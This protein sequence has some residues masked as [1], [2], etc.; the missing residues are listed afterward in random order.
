MDTPNNPCSPAFINKPGIKPGSSLS[1]L[2]ITGKTSVSKNCEHI[3]FTI[4]CSS[5]NSSGIK[6]EFASTSLIIHSPPLIAVE[7]F[8]IQVYF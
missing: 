5:L 7:L 1:I 6:I 3:S 4:N 8:S 2:S